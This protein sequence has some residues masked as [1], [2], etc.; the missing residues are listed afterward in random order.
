MV[1]PPRAIGA[2]SRIRALAVNAAAERAGIQP[3]ASLVDA[4]L[5]CPDLK[6][7][8]HDEAACEAAAASLTEALCARFPTVEAAP[9]GSWYLGTRG[10]GLLYPGEGP[11]QR[12]V[13]ETA[14]AAGFEGQ[15]GIARNRFTARAAAQAG[16]RG[17]LD[18]GRLI[19]PDGEEAALLAPLP[20]GLLPGA[21]ALIQRLAPLGIRTLGAFAALPPT[22]VERRY[23]EQG[24]RLHRL[25]RGEDVDHIQAVR[26]PQQWRDRLDLDAPVQLAEGIVFLIAPLVEHLLG[27]LAQ[28]GRACSA[29]AIAL[30]LEDRSRRGV[31]LDL[32]APTERSS[33]VVDL[34]RLKLA[35]VSLSAGIVGFEVEVTRATPPA[36]N[37]QDL[38]ARARSGTGLAVTLARLRTCLE[39]EAIARARLGDGG[40]RPGDRFTLE[41]GLPPEMGPGDGPP[42]PAQPPG[43]ALRWFR[44]PRPI[45]A[46]P[47]DAERPR[48]IRLGGALRE[49]EQLF[50]PLL[51]D[52]GW[53]AGGGFS[54]RYY[55]LLLAGDAEVLVY[56]DGD[57]GRWFLEGVYD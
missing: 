40:Y 44:S 6:V 14:A 22:S 12:A 42:A 25:A 57:G 54:R 4:Q 34:L 17:W 45:T 35:Q 11:I 52:G 32:A 5:I 13:R 49:V 41:A 1:A 53:W 19:I 2:P 43:R 39:P 23:G 27:A 16:A 30:E 3:G 56:R 51:Y 28:E 33:V 46:L 37:Q 8:D 20:L 10:L 38:F 50:G 31:T 24:I 15:V 26:A 29:L 47:A 48:T 55:R 21:E 7:I 9:A 18:P 36:R